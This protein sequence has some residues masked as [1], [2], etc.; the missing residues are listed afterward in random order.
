MEGKVCTFIP[1]NGIPF[2]GSM[3]LELGGGILMELIRGMSVE[4]VVCIC[5]GFN[6]GKLT[7]LGRKSIGFVGLK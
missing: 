1:Y 3:F 7:G 6:D 5:I 2:L 4:L